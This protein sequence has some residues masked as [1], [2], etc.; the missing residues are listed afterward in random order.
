MPTLGHITMRKSTLD[1]G[2]EISMAQQALAHDST[3]QPP[4]NDRQRGLHQAD[5]SCSRGQSRV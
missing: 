4:C 3:I 5:E 1:D 2:K